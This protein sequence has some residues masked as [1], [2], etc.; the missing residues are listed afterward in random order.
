MALVDSRGFNLIPQQGGAAQAIGRGLGTMG[1]LQQQGQRNLALERQDQVRQALSGVSTPQPQ[2]QTQQQQ[3]LGEQTAGL[4]GALAEQPQPIKTQAEKIAIAKNID[5]AATNKI[6][7]DMG[8]DNASKRAEM[9][10]FAADLENTPFSMR[11]EKIMARSQK[12]RAE[13]RDATQ[14][15]KLLDLDEATQ[16]QGLLGIQLADLS[17]KERLTF[18]GKEAGA[19]GKGEQ[20]QSSDILPDGTT[21]QSLK[22][23]GTKV[24]AADGTV[25]EGKERATA[26]RKAQEFGI[27]VQKRRAKGRG[28]GKGTSK[29][30]LKAFD[31]VGTIRE[32]ID[33]LQEGIRL[34]QE[35]GAETGPIAD[36]MPSFRAGTRKL[37]NLR[38]KLGLNVVGSVTFGALS[39]G[40]LKLAMDV[41]L[42]DGLSEAEIV[43]WMET[44]IKAQQKLAD[45]LEDAALFLSDPDNDVGDLIRRNR[46]QK[47]EQGKEN[48]R[49]KA[50]RKTKAPQG[51]TPTGKTATNPQTGERL[52]EMSDGTWSAI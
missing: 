10:R 11:R 49:L 14:T 13:G 29:I 16:N 12:L 15:D 22:G 7:K 31:Q 24:I 9:S 28:I 26:I 5:P 37:Q 47:I 19:E 18:R 4:G 2:S 30:A 32:N 23:G 40:E 46:K 17:T 27:D 3:Q 42:P 8:L 25:L 33:D 36:R 41:A 34:V 45:N 38:K 6:L 1:A 52:Q 44:R 35:E 48:K 43:N 50:E 21:V 39:E 51:A 20:V